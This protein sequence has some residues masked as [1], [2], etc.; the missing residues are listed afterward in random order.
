CGVR[1]DAGV[2]AF[3]AAGNGCAVIRW[4]S[5]PATSGMHRA[6]VRRFT[7]DRLGAS[8]RRILRHTPTEGLMAKLGG[9]RFRRG[10]A[11]LPSPALALHATR[12]MRTNAR[13]PTG[14]VA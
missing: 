10:R 7:V 14:L 2:P 9:W 3:L 1:H 6:R 8:R 4:L 5:A 11:R 13:L 12:L